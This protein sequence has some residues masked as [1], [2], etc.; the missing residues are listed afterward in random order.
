MKS[1]NRIVFFNILSTVVLQGITFFTSPVFSRMLGTV[2][3]GIVSVYTTW[4]TI[5][6]SV[7]SLNV[8]STLNVARLNF[9]EKDKEKYQSSVLFLGI[10]SYLVFGGLIVVLLNPLSDLMKMH[11][12][13]IVMLLA[14]SFEQFCVQM[15]NAKFTYEFEAGKNCILSIFTTVSSVALSLVLIYQLPP[16]ENYWGRI[17]GQVIA[18]AFLAIIS[19]V[20]F[21]VKGKTLFNRD[22]WKFCLPLSIPIIF[23]S[24]SNLVLEQSDRVMLQHMTSES[25]VGIY[26]LASSF[27]AVVHIIWTSLNNSWSPFY[28]EYTNQGKI[29][30]MRSHARNY[31]ELFTVLSAGFVLLATEVY[32]VF[33]GQDFWGG[34]MLIPIL[35]LGHYFVFLYSFPVNYEFYHKKTGLVATVTLLAAIVNIILNAVFISMYGF[36]GAGIATCIAHGVQ[37]VFHFISARFIIKGD[38]FPFKIRFFM[39]YFLAFVT[40]VVLVFFTQD[41]WYL[42]WGI[43]AAIGIFELIRIL[44]RKS[45]F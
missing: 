43:G 21:L 38:V 40:V 22:Y 42:R 15:L 5:A 16:E 36:I 32:H 41:L 35:A 20:F 6:T 30:Q 25:M 28:Y 31:V 44:K 33:A 39:P 8:H 17:L 19:C 2:N 7:F 37:F 10:L 23:H 1:S 4:C 9:P 29:D 26:S 18:Y 11:K 14:H 24:L 13:M 12:F 34:T 45:I 3:F 27:S